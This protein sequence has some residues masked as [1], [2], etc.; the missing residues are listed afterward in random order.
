[1]DDEQYDIVRFALQVRFDE[2]GLKERQR[3]TIAIAPLVAGLPPEHYLLLSSTANT[4][5]GYLH[6]ISKRPHA[7]AP[8]SLDRTW[9]IEDMRSWKS[10]EPTVF[11]V[12]FSAEEL[13][14]RTE[15]QYEQATFLNALVNLRQQVAGSTPITVVEQTPTNPPAYTSSK[16]TQNVAITGNLTVNNNGGV[17]VVLC[18]VCQS[19]LNVSGL[20]EASLGPTAAVTCD[21]CKSRRRVNAG[22]QEQKDYGQVLAT[23]L[24]GFIQ[25]GGIP[26]VLEGAFPFNT[27]GRFSDMYR[28]QDSRERRLAL[29]RPRFAEDQY[30]VDDVRLREAADGLAYIH[31]HGIIHGDVKGSNVLVSDDVHAKICDFGLA[32]IVDTNTSAAMKGAGSVRWQAPEMWKKAPRSKQTDVYSF[33]IMISEV[34][35]GDIPFAE[36]DINSAVILAV[37]TR[38]ERPC[39]TP[40]V[41]PTGRSYGAVWD[42]AKKCWEKEPNDRPTMQEV[43]RSLLEA[44]G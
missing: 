27:T 39:T 30:T 40:T 4:N 5:D 44:E 9:R 18:D 3:G 42:V 7:S 31:E 34:L 20:Q 38:D 29:K 28:A 32:K 26:L 37:A 24:S 25:P 22:A 17:V 16:P 12:I 43:H 15:N 21:G 14:W 10:E 41:S 13:R 11:S 33:G 35:N 36:Y 2:T 19:G 23:Q 8:R 1:M 6:L